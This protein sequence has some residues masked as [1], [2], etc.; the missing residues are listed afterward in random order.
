MNA[1]A[2]MK[3][4]SIGNLRS[5]GNTFQRSFHST[6]EV[7]M[8][9]KGWRANK[10][11]GKG[12]RKKKR[13]IGIYYKPRYDQWEKDSAKTALLSPVSNIYLLDQ[14]F[15]I[16]RTFCFRISTIKKQLSHNCQIYFDS[17]LIFIF[18]L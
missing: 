12:Y 7:E 3:T 4:I 17:F 9:M 1:L 11:E 10:K 14:L 18:I 13:V 16:N 5:E 2:W 8:P 15:L 6:A